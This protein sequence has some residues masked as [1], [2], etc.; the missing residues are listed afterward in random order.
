VDGVLTDGT[1]VI[2]GRPGDE[3]VFDSRRRRAGLGETGRPRDGLLS[4]RASKP[5]RPRRSRDELVVQGN[6]NKRETTDHRRKIT[7]GHA[8]GHARHHHQDHRRQRPQGRL[9][10]LLAVVRHGQP[11]SHAGGRGAARE[12]IELILKA[13]GNWDAV[14]TR[15]QD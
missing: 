4:G 11:R 9:D 10:P 1:V 2:S 12:F 8:R 3:D 7:A 15:V 14:L 6:T 5:R 13:R